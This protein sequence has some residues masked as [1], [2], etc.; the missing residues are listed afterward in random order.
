MVLLLTHKQAVSAHC[1]ARQ[2]PEN[3]G[4]RTGLSSV[5]TRKSTLMASGDS[6]GLPSAL[7]SFI[8]L[9]LVLFLDWELPPLSLLS[10][11]GFHPL[12]GCSEVFL[13]G[14]ITFT[15]SYIFLFFSKA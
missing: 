9:T 2:S 13:S 12:W 15:H 5:C 4:K 10:F 14:A 7:L 11:E 3:R 6:Q 1:G 8:H